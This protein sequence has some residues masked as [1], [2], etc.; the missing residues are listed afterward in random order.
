MRVT[1]QYYRALSGHRDELAST[2]Y[3]L[4]SDASVSHTPA[5]AATW[6]GKHLA[7]EPSMLQDDCVS[8]LWRGRLL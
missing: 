4:Y 7:A 8:A 3:E 5:V 2:S 6:V 1:G